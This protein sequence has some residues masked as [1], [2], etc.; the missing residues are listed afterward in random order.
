MCVMLQL[1]TT[2]PSADSHSEATCLLQN[3]GRTAKPKFI[4]VKLL[5]LLLLL[6][7]LS[8]SSSLLILFLLLLLSSSLLGC[9][10]LTWFYFVCLFLSFTGAHFLIGPWAV[11]LHANKHGFNLI[12]LFLLYSAR[13][14]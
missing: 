1:R 11:E 2:V 4:D 13:L 7:L 10:K 14:L 12:E 8:S 9:Y 3:L 6:L 5:L